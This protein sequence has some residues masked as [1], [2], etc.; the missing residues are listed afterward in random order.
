VS[1]DAE[2]FPPQPIR[3]VFIRHVK[4]T[5]GPGKFAI[6][7]LDF[8]RSRHHTFELTLP[9]NLSLLFAAVDGNYSDNY[10]SIVG[11]LDA[12][13]EGLRTEFEQVAKEH[14]LIIGTTAILR[15]IVIHPIDSNDTAFRE[16]G[17]MAVR[18]ALER[19]LAANEHGPVPG[20]TGAT[21][22]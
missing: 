21:S 9:N 10:R 22:T 3:D 17:R 19:A 5:S 20:T 14:E 16:A 4:Q 8:E 1:P 15:R 11:Y 12:L 18:T 2:R 7:T 6:V 13:A